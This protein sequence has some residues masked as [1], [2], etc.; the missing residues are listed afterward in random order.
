MKS[1]AELGNIIHDGE[2][3]SPMGAWK[4]TLSEQDKRNVL[5]YIRSLAR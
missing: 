2:P 1:N 4:W 5:S 3:G